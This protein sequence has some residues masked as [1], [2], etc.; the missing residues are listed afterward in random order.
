MDQ[1]QGKTLECLSE[2]YL[3]F[4]SSSHWCSTAEGFAQ[5]YWGARP[6]TKLK[7]ALIF[8]TRTAACQV[9]LAFMLSLLLSLS[10]THTGHTHILHL[11]KSHR[12]QWE[13]C[14]F[15]SHASV[16]FVCSKGMSLYFYQIFSQFL[17]LI[18]P[19]SCRHATFQ[20]VVICPVKHT[21][22][23]NEGNSE[24]LIGP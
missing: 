8:V 9:C 2:P 20:L 3:L 4:F 13:H 23:I 10:Q 16:V 7:M 19:S 6:L 18:L 1:D 11:G 21:P 22:W 17:L 15:R 24:Q 5:D 14:Y 12:W